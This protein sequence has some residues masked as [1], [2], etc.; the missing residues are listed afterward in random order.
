MLKRK[1]K[2]NSVQNSD[3][4]AN[5]ASFANAFSNIEPHQHFSGDKPIPESILWENKMQNV[6]SANDDNIYIAFSWLI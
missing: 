6:I 5:D 2:Y 4:I 3:I 1:K